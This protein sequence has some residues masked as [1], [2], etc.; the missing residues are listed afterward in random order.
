MMGCSTSVE[1]Q[2]Q[3][4]DNQVARAQRYQQRYPG[5]KEFL[6]Q[7]V[8]AAEKVKR[9]ADGLDEKAGIEKMKQAN[10]SFGPLYTEL[11]RL[12]EIERK[13]RDRL[14]ELGRLDA[15]SFS[16]DEERRHLN[17]EADR[18]TRE[19][20]RDLASVKAE[21]E[22]GAQDFVSRQNRRL[23][24]LETQ[25]NQAVS[26]ARAKIDKKNQKQR[27]KEEKQQRKE[28]KKQQRKEEKKRQK[29]A[30]EE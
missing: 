15:D 29:E 2:S 7:G 20:E 13:L 27:E 22:A 12:E 3:A 17:E 11:V 24:D 8:D 21:S 14:Q 16:S 1:K 19:V 5:F 6:A 25:V 26:R 18:I 28:E 9:E 30:K 10:A 23:Y 4:F